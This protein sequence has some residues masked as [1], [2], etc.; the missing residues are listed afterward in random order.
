MDRRGSNLQAP[1]PSP[2]RDEHA[3]A[4]ARAG[5]AAWLRSQRQARGL[6]LD[7][8]ARVTRIQMRALER[9]ED[10]RFH[11]LPADVFVRGFI[12]NYARVVGVDAELAL[13]RYD[14]CGVT[15][16]PAAAARAR[17]MLDTMAPL[18]PTQALPRVLREPTA[19][20]PAPASLASGSLRMPTQPIEV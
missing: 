19:A 14:D 10:G 6:E 15:P 9:L 18:A 2:S 3:V 1:A 20:P 11:E 4:H 5:F 7:D 8:I 17:A 16:G 13:A 12:R